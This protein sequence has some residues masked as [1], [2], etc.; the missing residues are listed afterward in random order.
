MANVVIFE[1]VYES[2]GYKFDIEVRLSDDGGFMSHVISVSM[3]DG[4][5]IYSKQYATSI[6]EIE[7]NLEKAY[8]EADIWIS[9]RNIKTEETKLLVK[10]GFTIQ[11]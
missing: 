7:V 5:I 2:Y 1:K 6:P 11:K 3:N 9:R 4:N 10:L 8:T